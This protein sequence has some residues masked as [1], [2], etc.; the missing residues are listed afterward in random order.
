MRL[1]GNNNFAYLERSAFP[2]EPN[3]HFRLDVEA[4]GQLDVLRQSGLASFASLADLEEGGVECLA[5]VGCEGRR[6]TLRGM[7]AH[8]PLLATLPRHLAAG[9]ALVSSPGAQ[10]Y[11]SFS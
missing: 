1:G 8:N 10:P 4:L 6:E 9:N 11:Q 5:V 3:P 2:P 7:S